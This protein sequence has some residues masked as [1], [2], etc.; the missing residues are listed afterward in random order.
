MRI[1]RVNFI[2]P[3]Y[4]IE[5]NFYKYYSSVLATLMYFGI[6]LNRT[7]ILPEARCVMDKSTSFRMLDRLI[8]QYSLHYSNEGNFT[9]PIPYSLP[10][11]PRYAKGYFPY[12]VRPI[13]DRL[14]DFELLNPYLNS[15]ETSIKTFL[16]IASETHQQEKNAAYVKRDDISFEPKYFPFFPLFPLI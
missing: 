14:S 15:N 8:Q 11:D 2:F 16:K 1:Y 9:K 12:Y 7:V 4:I 13:F 10:F 3:L 6:K 5:K